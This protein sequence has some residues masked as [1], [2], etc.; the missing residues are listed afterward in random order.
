MATRWYYTTGNVPYSDPYG[1][2]A[3]TWD[4][5]TEAIR[6]YIATAAQSPSP[7]EH[8]YKP[9]TEDTSTSPAQVLYV[10]HVTQPLAAQTLLQNA[11]FRFQTVALETSGS[12]NGFLCIFVKH[13]NASHVLQNEIGYG[14]GPTELAASG[15]NRYASVTVGSNI[16]ISN[17]DYLVFETGVEGQNSMSNAYRADLIIGYNSSNSDLG[18]NETDT[19]TTLN[20]WIECSQTLTFSSGSAIK[21]VDGLAKASISKMQGTALASMKTLQGTA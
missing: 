10:Q 2:T 4:I 6:R 13:Y 5:T 7:W 20:P 17:D 18:S 16:S 19:S 3:I 21:S 14:V 9:V 8:S 11:T 1:G 15:V 12:L